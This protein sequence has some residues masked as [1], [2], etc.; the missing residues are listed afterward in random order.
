MAEL[1]QLW[2]R[3][4]F[5]HSLTAPNL[6]TGLGYFQTTYMDYRSI[7]RIS[8]SDLSELHNHIFG[9]NRPKPVAAFAFGSL[10][11]SLI[12]EPDSNPDVPTGV[13][14]DWLA[15]ER[16]SEIAAGDEHLQTLLRTS[17]KEQVILWDCPDTGLLLKSKIDIVQRRKS[18][19][20]D[21]KTTSE[22]TFD[23]FMQSAIKYDYNR[24]AAF[25]LDA[26]GCKSFGFSV[27]QKVAP[28]NIWHIE[29]DTDSEFIQAGRKKYKRLLRD[30]KQREVMGNPF[31]PSTWTTHELQPT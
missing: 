23:S 5:H 19:V 3:F 12:L 2:S 31:T 22:K 30:W 8:N 16:I 28:F 21:L 29:F 15:I 25:Y 4:I 7:P 14:L 11:H 20:V 6:E 9:I 1:R 10:V 24:Q 26:A 13:S 18:L 17:K 27:I